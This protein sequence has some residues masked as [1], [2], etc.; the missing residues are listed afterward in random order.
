[1]IIRKSQ[2]CFGDSGFTT[3]DFYKQ[4]RENGTSYV[5]QLKKNGIL[6]EKASH[7]MDE[8]DEITKN[9]KVDYAIVYGEFMYKSKS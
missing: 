6:R 7:L 2:F 9:N 4:C 3:P 1:M 8:L 5:S